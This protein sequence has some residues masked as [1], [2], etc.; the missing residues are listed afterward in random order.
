MITRSFVKTPR[1][2]PV[3]PS[4]LSSLCLVLTGLV[5]A[6]VILLWAVVLVPQWLRRHE[7]NAE[8]RT[9]LTFHRAMRTLERRRG[10]RGVSKASHDVDV[11]VAGA[12]S[13]VHDRVSLDDSELSPID[14]H[15]DSGSDPFQ[16]SATEEHLRHVRL[17]RAK[18][19][20][21]ESASTRR[22]QV[23]QA[24]VGISVIGF[25][26]MVMGIVPMLLALSPVATLGAFWYL[27]RRQTAAA[28]QAQLRRVRR[29]RSREDDVDDVA[30]T[31]RGSSSSTQRGASSRQTRRSRSDK[32][33]DSHRSGRSRRFGA[34]RHVEAP[35]A[36]DSSE[37]AIETADDFH[38]LS[39]E[40]TQT[41]RTSA[42]AGRRW[43]PSEAP[44][45]GYLESARATR[46]P[47]NIDSSA[48][49]DWT[50]ERMVEQAEALRTPESDAEF[51]LGLDDFVAIPGEDV[52]EHGYSH[53]RAVND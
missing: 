47:R 50:G 17:L 31:E 8:H 37:S 49:G 52:D 10:N 41:R 6:A 21:S 24:L 12:R 39:D 51:E 25:V 4:R 7:R 48:S 38:L 2:K 20:A 22:R 44:L 1:R 23:Q 9:T 18:S 11:T 30:P 16:G 46:M 28:E 29:E 26:L 40:E 34:R 33:A 5:Y 15:L 19:H 14:E 43:E 27:G 3:Q 13:R 35:A 53:H 36:R 32:S 45:P 42:A